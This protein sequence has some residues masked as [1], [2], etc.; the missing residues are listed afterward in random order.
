LAR[1]EQAKGQTG[2]PGR[3]ISNNQQ[4]AFAFAGDEIPNDANGKQ[5]SENRAEHRPHDKYQQ[6]AL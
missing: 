2:K 3:M 5:Q 6:G 4:P 1:Q